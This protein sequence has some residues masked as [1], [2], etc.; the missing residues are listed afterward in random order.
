MKETLKCCDTKSDP[1]IALLQ[2]RST[3]LGPRL[4][5]PTRLLFNH[6]IRGI[7]PSINRS[8][9]GV[10]SD[11]EYYEALVKRQRRNDKNDDTSRNYALIPIGSTVDVQ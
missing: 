3:P 11:D 7:M 2:I 8:L 1:H 6:P 9:I 4:P 5:S 10:S